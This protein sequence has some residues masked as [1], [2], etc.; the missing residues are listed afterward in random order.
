MLRHFC[1]YFDINY[2]TRGLTLHWS[3][4]QNSPSFRLY[5]LCM[6]DACFA[7]LSRL[8][9][10]SIV[11]VRLASLEAHD[12]ALLEAKSN[13]SRIEYYFTCTA[14]FPLFIMKEWEDADLVTYLDA[15]LFFF[16][17]PEH[18]FH[19]LGENS[20]GIIAHRFPPHLEDRTQYGIY[21]VGWLSFRRDADGIECLKWWRDQ[22]IEWCYDRVEE[23]RFA[24]QKYLDD[25]P[26]RFHGVAVLNH[27]GGNLAPWNIAS[28]TLT[29]VNGEVKV[30]GRPLV[31]FHFHGL[32]QIGRW[33]YDPSW[34]EYGI[35]SSTVLRT[36]IYRPYIRVLRHFESGRS[37]AALPRGV[38]L[39]TTDSRP[40]GTLRQLRA[41]VRENRKRASEIAKG[42]L[43]VAVGSET[44]AD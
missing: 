22:C 40:R 16:S 7:E 5:V 11:P 42:E 23:N 14:A 3:L 10:S 34:K 32:K 28:H 36:M 17:T 20:V 41:T 18:L 1:T 33:L 37:S 26:K 15:D 9:I 44:I 2:L 4:R 12:P 43:I 38:R 35:S 24:D 8:A 29:S 30:D 19:E 13:R 21:N 39:K 25:W 6:D 27:P 31:F